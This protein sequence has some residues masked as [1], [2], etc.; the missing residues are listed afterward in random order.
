MAMP[1]SDNVSEHTDACVG[2]GIG[3]KMAEVK[4]SNVSKVYPGGVKAV[5]NANLT[6]GEAEF[7]VLVVLC[8]GFLGAIK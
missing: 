4:V 1:G 7:V 6:I 3:V 5:V 2:I 8:I